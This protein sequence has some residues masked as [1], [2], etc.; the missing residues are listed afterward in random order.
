MRR[1]YRYIE[2]TNPHLHWW[3]DFLDCRDDNYRNLRTREQR[4]SSRDVRFQPHR[5]F[6]RPGLDY[7]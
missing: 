5:T 7:R 6:Y 2:E 1:S 3:T 4:S